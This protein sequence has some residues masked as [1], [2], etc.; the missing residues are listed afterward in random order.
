MPVPV[1]ARV[2]MLVMK[3]V[4]P[5]KHSS[6]HSSRGSPIRRRRGDAAARRD[7]SSGQVAIP[8]SD[9]HGVRVNAHC[10]GQVHSVVAA[11]AVGF[12]EVSRG[13]GEVRVETNDLQFGTEVLDPVDGATQCRRRDSA[14]SPGRGCCRSGLGVDQLARHD[15]FCAIPQLGR[16]RRSW[17]VEH[18]LDQ[19]GGVEINDQ[20][21]CSRTRSETEP[22]A[23]SSSRPLARRRDRC[24]SRTRP[25]AR[26]SASGSAS[27]TVESRAI[28]RPRIVTTT[29]PPDS[30]WRR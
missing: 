15:R 13:A 29:R 23:V 9:Q 18:Q 17:F 20:R 8:G 24:G 10:G 5:A 7:R 14:F 19:G 16:E 27:P 28:R 11:Q 2:S 30:T 4:H 21:R 6:Q 1:L 3:Y 12:G 26:R 25:R 22:C